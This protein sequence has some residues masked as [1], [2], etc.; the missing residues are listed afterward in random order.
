MESQRIIFLSGHLPLEHEQHL[1]LH[2]IVLTDDILQDKKM[3]CV[4][5]HY[6]ASHRTWFAEVNLS[7]VTLLGIPTPGWQMW[8]TVY[9]SA[10]L[11]AR[12][13]ALALL[14]W[15]CIY[16][17]PVWASTPHPVPPTPVGAAGGNGGSGTA[18]PAWPWKDRG[19]GQEPTSTR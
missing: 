12:L 18:A 9:G 2:Q 13:A 7:S 1:L 15:P 19:W 10:V 4:S 11:E 5:S 8:H 6:C 17:V 16:V 14:S 3:C